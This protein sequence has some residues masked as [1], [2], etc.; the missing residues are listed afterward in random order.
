M[1]ESP[2][3]EII[4]ALVRKGATVRAYDPVAMNEAKHCLPNIEYATDEYDALTGA[5][6]L[7]IVT[8][9][10]QFRA[11]DMEKVK[12]LLNA[13]RIA[14]LRNIYEPADMRALGFEYIGVG[15]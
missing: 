1:R 11:L 14:D 15:R 2:A 3:I 5:D 13:P 9:W 7:V 4:E 12:G 10:N 8:E 6:A